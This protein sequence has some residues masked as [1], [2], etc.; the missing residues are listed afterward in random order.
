MGF[1]AISTRMARRGILRPVAD[2]EKHAFKRDRR[3]IVRLVLLLAIALLAGV[4]LWAKMTSTSF[5][6]CAA[7]AFGSTTGEEGQPPSP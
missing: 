3:F 4:F 2:L 6:T 1:E 5:G 7:G